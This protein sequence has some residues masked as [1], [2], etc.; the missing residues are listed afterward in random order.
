M[1]FKP[2]ICSAELTVCILKESI[3]VTDIPE[4]QSIGTVT[5]PFA[6]I[7]DFTFAEASPAFF[8]ESANSSLANT[9][10]HLFQEQKYGEPE[11]QE[12]RIDCCIRKRM[13]RDITD[14]GTIL[15]STGLL[16][17]SVALQIDLK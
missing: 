5:T 7:A 15:V 16:A 2:S 1:F 8:E 9:S 6:Y 12:R 11:L 13:V 10:G 4:A 3:F 17:S 14:F